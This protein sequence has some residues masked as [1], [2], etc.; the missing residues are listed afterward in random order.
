MADTKIII[1]TL[2]EITL[3][4]PIS[5]SLIINSSI[6]LMIV[7]LL[8]TAFIGLFG[9]SRMAESLD[10]LRSESNQIRSGINQSI[11]AL[12][13]IDSEIKQLSKSEALFSK[14]RALEGELKTV[15]SAST[16][17]DHGLKSLNKT[18]NQ[19]NDSLVFLGETTNTLASQVKLLTSH[20]Q[21]LQQDAKEAQY[22]TLHSYL[23]YFEFINGSVDAIKTAKEDTQTV[24]SKIGSITKSLAKVNAPNDTR[25]L[26]VD[27]KKSIRAYSRLFRKLSKFK[28]NN[29]PYELNQQVVT[30]GR[31]LLIMSKQLQDAIGALANNISDQ[32]NITAQSAAQ[33][34]AKSREVSVETKK[35][36]DHSLAIVD[37]SNQKMTDFTQ[38]LST[39]LFELGSS[40]S[41][42]PK[43]SKSVSQS[44]KKM[45]L[46]VSA[47][48]I[49]RL[50]EAEKRAENAK[51]E[52]KQLPLIL[53]S[54]SILAV[55]LSVGAA[56][57]VYR[58][59][60][61]PL[62]RFVRGVKRVANNDL[63]QTV[64][65]DGSLGE[66]QDVIHGLNSLIKTLRENV[67]DMSKAGQN[68]SANVEFF[69]DTSLESCQALDAQKRETETMAL[70]AEALDKATSEMSN[71][72]DS[73]AEAAKTASI[74]VEMGQQTVTES[75]LVS[76]Q[77]S[78]KIDATFE[79]MQLL[80]SDSDNIGSVIDVIRSIAEQTNLLAL[81]AAIEAAR[82]GES[83]RG[84][85]VVADEVRNLANSTGDSVDEI[86]K[87]IDRLQ[88]STKQGARSIEEGRRQV[89][90]N[91]KASLSSE[92]ALSSIIESVEMINKM[93]QQIVDSSQ[94]QKSTVESLK[95]NV[96]NIRH[97][98]E[99]T[100]NTDQKHVSSINK[101]TDTAKNLSSLV[102]RFS[103]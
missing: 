33:A 83:G 71:S 1:L 81:N 57:F 87:L 90:L 103:I 9:T 26:A 53:L 16:D 14:L 6:V 86:E 58:R 11:N 41:V 99:E 32:A 66:L 60:V 23:S 30:A 34:V 84:F 36:L 76:S 77:L 24:F 94:Q 38:Q 64:N 45:Q 49:N 88:V 102:D 70:A 100:E 31:A 55:L 28:G 63:T 19:Q 98:A 29:V 27:I 37:E 73:A 8:I 39:V 50:E 89:D 48:D 20:M 3:K 65:D 21:K 40:L 15:S 72:A 69:K 92:Q 67:G 95:T 51:Q 5:I 62:S 47:E 22:Y 25:R 52:A 54:V 43:V 56:L 91:V 17:I 42:V 96:R 35:V 18:N 80:K 59:L 68:I 44:V 82:A 79:T 2:R 10:F 93:N 46:F 7:L 4:K 75:R 85:A 74:A 13:E 78:E 101:L 97:L 12:G 61:K